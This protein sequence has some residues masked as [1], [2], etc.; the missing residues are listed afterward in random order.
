[1]NV[2]VSAVG[3]RRGGAVT[4]L[5]QLVVALDEF[6]VDR[7]CVVLVQEGATAVLPQRLRSVTIVPVAA[8]ST[9]RRMLWDQFTLPRLCRALRAD[10][11]L[12]LLNFGPRYSACPQ[13]V[14]Q[15]NP[16]YFLPGAPSPGL[17]G[18]V[19]LAVR[20]RMALAACRGSRVVVTPSREMQAGVAQCLGGR[21][22]VVVLPHGMDVGFFRPDPANLAALPQ[23]VPR[24]AFPRLAYVSHPAPHKGHADV[25]SAFVRIRQTFPSACLA[26]TLDESEGATRGVIERMRELG[27]RGEALEG[28]TLTGR[29]GRE[30]VRALYQ[31]AD[32]AVFPTHRESFGF[33]LLEAMAMGTPVVASDL[34]CLRELGGDAPLYHRVGD[35]AE[36]ATLVE[37]LA[38]DSEQRY[39]RAARGGARAMEHGMVDYVKRLLAI[40][41]TATE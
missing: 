37:L 33:P 41:D 32:I 8:M 4:H 9:P 35:T 5:R 2:V 1:M 3:A 15:R 14:M 39:A 6:V 19:E 34:A 12:C 27:K 36:L 31:W 7:H 22:P 26:L 30:Q 13:V 24:Q 40:L 16:L 11:L 21:R 38:N 23:E 28:V 10:V 17:T 29:L 18:R 20:K 25:L